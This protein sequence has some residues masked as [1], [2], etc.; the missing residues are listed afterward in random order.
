[1]IKHQQKT[2]QMLSMLNQLSFKCLEISMNGQELN[3]NVEKNS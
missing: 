3:K 2:K 1:M